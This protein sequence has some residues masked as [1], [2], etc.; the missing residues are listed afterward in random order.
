MRR[1]GMASSCG[2]QECFAW[3]GSIIILISASLLTLFERKVLGYIQNRKGPSEVEC[4]GL[5]QPVSD[6]IKV[7]S[8]EFL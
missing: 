2:S 6:V 3:K 5:L 8:K 7:L 4:L 1:N